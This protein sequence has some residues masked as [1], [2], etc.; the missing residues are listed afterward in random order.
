MEELK[1][2]KENLNQLH[3][4]QTAYAG[5]IYK[6]EDGKLRDKVLRSP[7]EKLHLFTQMLK[8]ESV[9]KNAKIIQP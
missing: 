8:R 5:F 7:M 2:H 3:E 6:S 9:L 1:L 4:D